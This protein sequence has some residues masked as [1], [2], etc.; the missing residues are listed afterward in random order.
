MTQAQI[1]KVIKQKQKSTRNNN[2][3]AMNTSVKKKKSTPLVE[4]INLQ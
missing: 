4:K 3:L 1:P 2:G